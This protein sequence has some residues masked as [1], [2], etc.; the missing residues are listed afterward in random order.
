VP[1]YDLDGKVAVITGASTGFGVEFAR[2]FAESGAHVVLAA[3]RLDLLEQVAH[4]V[5]ERYGTRALPVRTD[6]EREED[7]VRLVGTAAAELGTVDCLVNNAGM[8][9]GKPLLEHT[10]ADWRRVMTCNLTAAFVGSR[11]AARVMVDRGTHGSIVNVAS[12]LGFVVGKPFTIVSYYASKH[13][14]IAMTKALAVELGGSRIRVNALAPAF[15]PTPMSEE[16]FGPGETA[17]W[18]RSE[19]ILRWSATPDLPRNEWIK[20]A[21]CFLASDDATYITGA[22]LPVDG[23][24]LAF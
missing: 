13:G 10:L 3:R 5:E 4:E 24:W 16:V 14:M 22:T 1:R 23:G 8:F 21:A 9:I 2:G 17:E 15:F 6:V 19:V 12:I 18:L 11:E 20:G 7:V